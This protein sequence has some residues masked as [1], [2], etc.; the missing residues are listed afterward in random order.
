M[1]NLKS[2]LSEHKR[3]SRSYELNTESEFKALW[4]STPKGGRP[5]G[6]RTPAPHLASREDQKKKEELKAEA[7]DM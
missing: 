1:Q 7:S 3:N 4:P 5:A 2:L 6:V